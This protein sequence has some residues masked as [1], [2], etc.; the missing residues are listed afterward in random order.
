M[1]VGDVC[2]SWGQGHIEILA[3]EWGWGQFIEGEGF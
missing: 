1:I 3:M 2:S